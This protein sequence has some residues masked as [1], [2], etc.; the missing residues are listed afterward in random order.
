MKRAVKHQKLR[1]Y[2]A[3]L[4]RN[5]RPAFPVYIRQVK[6]LRS[7][8]KDACLADASLYQGGEGSPYFL[9][10]LDSS[11]SWD[12]LWESLL[13]EWA[14]CLAWCEGHQSLD[15]HDALWGVAY[16]MVYKAMDQA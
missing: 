5:L 2:T 9:I 8:K 3:R 11:Q 4:R 15:D 1:K 12:S 6:G 10:R 7:R 13:H 16:A 14:H